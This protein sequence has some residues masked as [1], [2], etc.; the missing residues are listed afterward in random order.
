MKKLTF[1]L[2][3]TLTAF[4]MKAQTADEVVEKYLKAIGGADKWKKLESMI[5]TA[6]GEQQGFSFPITVTAM[7]PNLTKIE[8]DVQG[9]KLIPQ[10]YDGTVGWS[11]NPFA[12]GNEPTKMDEE[13]TKEMAKEKFEDD[14]IDYKTKGHTVAL[15]GTEEAEGTK[16]FKIKLTLK[17]GSEKVY[18]IDVD[19]YIPIMIRQFATFGPNKGQASETVLGDYKEVE[20][21]MMPHSIEQKAGGQTQAVIKVEK[22]EINPK[23]DKAIFAFPAAAKK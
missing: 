2:A 8:A 20:G 16:C 19:N 23:I 4:A 1:L 22:I 9:M 14:L 10:A 18:F 21:M 17:E 13:M 3:L 12:G 11:L 15:E 6:K 5:Q 7:R